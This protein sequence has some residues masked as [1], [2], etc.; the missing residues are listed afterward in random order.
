[1]KHITAAERI[2]WNNPATTAAKITVADTAN[3]FTAT[4]VEEALKELFIN[5]SD[6]KTR[7][8]NAAGAPSISSDTFTKIAGDITTGKAKIGAAIRGKDGTVNDKD[9]FETMAAAVSGI[10][11]FFIKP[12]STKVLYSNDSSKT[13]S[14]TSLQTMRAIRVGPGGSYRISYLANHF[15]GTS[16]IYIN[17]VAKGPLRNS[18]SG[19][20]TYDYDIVLKTG[21]LIEIKYNPYGGYG[22]YIQ[23]FR[24]FG[25]IGYTTII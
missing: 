3:L 16:Q 7:I 22:N 5:A 10:E 2:K 25:D 11:T 4:D 17:G 19:D 1:M 15:G 6:G 14:G 18:A 13:V 20:I 23:F 12:S 21:D 24:I 9:S 8:A